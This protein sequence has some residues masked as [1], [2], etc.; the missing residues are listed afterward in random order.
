MLTKKEIVKF[1]RDKAV[2]D[3]ITAKALL[4]EQQKIIPLSILN[5]PINYI[6]GQEKNLYKQRSKKDNF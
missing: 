1:W 6:Y 2:D 4:K 5:Q 3:R